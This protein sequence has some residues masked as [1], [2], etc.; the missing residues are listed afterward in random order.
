MFDGEHPPF[1]I[2][3]LSSM[4]IYGAAALPPERKSG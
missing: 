3:L 2:S 1:L 4:G